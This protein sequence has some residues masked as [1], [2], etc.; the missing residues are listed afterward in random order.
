VRIGSGT[1]RCAS[2]HLGLRPAERT[3]H[4]RALEE[5]IGTDGPP[6]IIGGDFNEFPSGR[7]ISSLSSRFVDA[8]TAAAR[9]G[10][11]DGEGEGAT[12]PATEPVARIDYVFVPERM[13]VRSARVPAGAETV[14]ASDHRPVVVEL[15]FANP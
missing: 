15:G 10:R 13:E 2:V 6:P 1:L 3:W 7:A 12:F 14:A 11:A 4:A 9:D 5:L 8:W